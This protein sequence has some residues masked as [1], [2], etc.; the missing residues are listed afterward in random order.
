MKQVVR[1]KLASTDLEKLDSLC[2]E[3]KEIATRTGAKVAGPAAADAEA[4][5]SRQEEPVWRGDEDL[6]EVGAPRP[7]EAYGPDGQRS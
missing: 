6:E 3:I 5:P 7:P 1:I 4:R 2:R